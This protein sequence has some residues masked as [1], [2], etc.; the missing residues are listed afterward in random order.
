M[1]KCKQMIALMLNPKLDNILAVFTDKTSNVDIYLIG[2]IHDD[3]E[4]SYDIVLKGPN[5][6]CEV[7]IVF[8]T[9]PTAIKGFGEFVSNYCIKSLIHPIIDKTCLQS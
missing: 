1:K 3:G 2:G 7:P 9:Y 4:E 6:M 8:N 5:Q